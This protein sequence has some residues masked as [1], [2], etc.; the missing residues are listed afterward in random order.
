MQPIWRTEQYIYFF[1]HE[2]RSQFPEE[3]MYIFYPPDWLQFHDVQGVYW[4]ISLRR[5]TIQAFINIPYFCMNMTRVITAHDLVFHVT[6]QSTWW[7]YHDGLLMLTLQLMTKVI[8]ILVASWYSY[9]F[10]RQLTWY[11]QTSL[12]CKSEIIKKGCLLTWRPCT[13]KRLT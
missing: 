1:L 9:L 8:L 10:D 5:L 2:N 13:V 4:S 12:Y 7:E 6:W 11:I 3:K